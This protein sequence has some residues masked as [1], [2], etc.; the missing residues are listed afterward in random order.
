M[1]IYMYIYIFNMFYQNKNYHPTTA[2]ISAMSKK[3]NIP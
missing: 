3:R 1:N 2:D